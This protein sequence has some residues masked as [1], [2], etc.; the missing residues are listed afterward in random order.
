VAPLTQCRRASCCLAVLMT[1]ACSDWNRETEAARFL[2]GLRPF[3][4]KLA[5]TRD[6]APCD[7][8]PDTFLV[9]VAVSCPGFRLDDAAL[10]SASRIGVALH[11]ASADNATARW[12]AATIDLVAGYAQ[13]AIRESTLRRLTEVAAQVPAAG[14]LNDLA[15]AW[16]VRAAA[17]QDPT[18]LFQALTW[19]ERALALDPQHRAARFNRALVLDRLSLRGEALDAW[20]AYLALDNDS[21]WARE[22]RARL[23]LLQA[24][25]AGAA[26]DRRRAA[27]LVRSGAAPAGDEAGRLAGIWP[28]AAREY[29]LEES[30][31]CWATAWLESRTQD[32]AACLAVMHALGKALVDANGDRNALDAAAIL[33]GAESSAPMADRLAHGLARFA[34]GRTA[35][36]AARFTDSEQPLRDALDL[37]PK[38][39]EPL[40]WL[41]ETLLGVVAMYRTDY[42]SAERTFD[43]QIARID[44]SAYPGAWALA[45]WG[46]GLSLARRGQFVRAA[47]HYDAA[48]DTH[49]RLG[50]TESQAAMFFLSGEVAALLGQYTRG[51]SLL[52]R[53]LRGLADYPASDQLHNML[54]NFGDRLAAAGFDEAAVA[55]HA[56]GARVAQRT[57]RAKDP[58]EALTWLGRAESRV[59]RYDEAGEH[60]A[61]A[62]SA[63][64]AVTDPIMHDR[65]DVEIIRGEASLQLARDPTHAGETI[66]RAIDY[67]ERGSLAVG[68]LSALAM[69]AEARLAVADSSGA[70]SDLERAV[71]LAENE[72]AGVAEGARFTLF[73]AATPAFDKLIAM[74]ISR[75]DTLGA[76]L[77]LERSRGS[78]SADPLPALA[79]GIVAL[80]FALLPDRLLTWVITADGIRLYEDDVGQAALGSRI[81]R[82]E[83]LLRQ[84]EDSAAINALAAELYE[85]LIS[86]VAAA[87][88]GRDEIVIVADK[89]LHRLPFAGLRDPRTGRWLVEDFTLRLVPDVRHLDGPARRPPGS[90]AAATPSTSTAFLIG[91]PAFDRSAFPGLRRLPYADREILDVGAHYH[92]TDTVRGAAATRSAVI[93]GFRN[94]RIVHFAGHA[95]F[96]PDN[97]DLSFLLLAPAGADDPGMLFGRDIRALDLSG[98]DL[99]VLSACETIST[100]AT[101]VGG[102]GGLAGAFLA[103]GAGGVVGSLW[104]AGDRPT[105]ALMSA[106]HRSFGSGLDPA[107]ALRAAQLEL[108]ASHDPALRAPGTWSAFR[109]QG[110]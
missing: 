108:I 102:F 70:R 110:R 30:T 26:A 19:L 90:A 23:E 71:T 72:A 107:R 62:R 101:R 85:T 88:D 53:S 28:Q 109:Y 12:R 47:T 39:A 36:E 37:L 100:Q 68:L 34:E 105:A 103:A 65:L 32:A 41:P 24:R 44:A 78:R 25:I 87:L 50:E 98:V 61:E 45:Q 59:G 10:V 82:F 16:T 64:P 81:D 60:L 56:E 48:A 77:D 86:P 18:S 89:D 83:N 46:M 21:D 11:Q 94:H 7:P 40:R 5:D 69:R 9:R 1:F 79:P 38:D 31:K 52:T 93:A 57:G 95:R 91:D 67:F 106:F 54:L 84:A 6:W 4:A 51:L 63:L 99:V 73:Q 96:R 8:A 33:E 15:V 43:A 27:E 3:E 74:R 104:E 92:E 55:L 97:P 58:V 35:F 76:F 17:E 80:D 66:G 20:S 13:P 42:A 14:T 22:A 75:N 29:A 2:V 49:G